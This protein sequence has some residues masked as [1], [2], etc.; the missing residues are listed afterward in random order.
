MNY[1]ETV[2]LLFARLPMFTRIGGAAYKANL[3][4]ISALLDALHHPEKDQKFVHVGGT[5]GKGS[6]SHLLASTLAE[7][8]YK[9]GLFT[10]PHIYDFRERIKINGKCISEKF[11]I[12]FTEKCIPFLIP[13]HLLSLNLPQ[14]WHS[15]TS[16]K[17]KPILPL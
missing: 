9:V 11:V 7:S 5:N 15:L 6:T 12:E 16:N 2:E 1:Q 3:D 4:N 8:G 14:P 10:S 13:L 17:K